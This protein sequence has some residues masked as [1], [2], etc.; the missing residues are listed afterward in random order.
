MTFAFST[1]VIWIRGN[2][3]IPFCHFAWQTCTVIRSTETSVEALLAIERKKQTY[4]Y[5]FCWYFNRIMILYHKY[6]FRC[7]WLKYYHCQKLFQMEKTTIST[8]LWLL[9]DVFGVCRLISG[10]QTFGC[11]FFFLLFCLFGNANLLPYC[12]TSRPLI[13]IPEKT[14]LVACKY[15]I[16]GKLL[17]FFNIIS[18]SLFF[19]SLAPCGGTLCK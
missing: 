7:C 4:S 10:C 12:H 16:S 6:F 14:L 3:W 17:S 5:A 18:F 13:S 9:Y 19:L 11:Y 15:H 8:L 1:F 2:N